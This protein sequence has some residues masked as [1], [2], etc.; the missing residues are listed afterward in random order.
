VIRT[1]DDTIVGNR[2]ASPGRQGVVNELVDDQDPAARFGRLL[3]PGE[4]AGM[5]LVRPLEVKHQ[6]HTTR[7]LRHSRVS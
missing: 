3:R 1:G 4:D 2:R 7:F 5:T 6:R